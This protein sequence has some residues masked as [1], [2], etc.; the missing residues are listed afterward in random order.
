MGGFREKSALL[1][2]LRDSHDPGSDFVILSEFKNQAMSDEH[3]RRKARNELS[4]N[5]LDEKARVEKL[6]SVFKTYSKI[7]STEQVDINECL[8]SDNKKKMSK[9]LLYELNLN[10]KIT[11]FLHM[12]LIISKRGLDGEE[13]YRTH[14]IHTPSNYKLSAKRHIT[15]QLSQACADLVR[16]ANNLAERGSGWSVSHVRRL[17]MAIIGLPGLRGGA[18]PSARRSPTSGA[19]LGY[20]ITPYTLYLCKYT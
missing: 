11:F 6:R 10:D 5:F 7:N 16:Q 20:D 4:R 3:E 9:L 13:V 14:S 18:G 1:A 8:S 15:A 17:D 2:H 12:P 19:V